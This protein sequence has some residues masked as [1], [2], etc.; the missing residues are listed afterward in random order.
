MTATQDLQN[1]IT[2][3]R[4]WFHMLDEGEQ[5]DAGLSSLLA[6]AVTMRTALRN[7]SV[8]YRRICAAIGLIVA[9][10]NRNAW[11]TADLKTI[12]AALSIIAGKYPALLPL[13]AQR[14]IE[15]VRA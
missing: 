1:A 8:E 3:Y 14:T 4:I 10:I 5:V 12:E 11:R 2:S 13:S 7:K 15:R 9:C 6:M